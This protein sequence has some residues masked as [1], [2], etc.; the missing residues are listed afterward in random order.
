MLTFKGRSKITLTLY[1]DLLRSQR[2]LK[3]NGEGLFTPITVN[4]APVEFKRYR[5]LRKK[6][7]TARLNSGGSGTSHK[8]PV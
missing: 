8:H 3:D 2:D 7:L 6:T 5:V 1:S 4:Y